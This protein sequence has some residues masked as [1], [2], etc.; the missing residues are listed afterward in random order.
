MCT[1]FQ[2]EE[3]RHARDV[4]SYAEVAALLSHLTAIRRAYD[5]GIGEEALF[6]EDGASS[7]LQMFANEG[8][9]HFCDDDEDW[10]RCRFA[11]DDAPLGWRVIQLTTDL[12]DRRMQTEGRETIDVMT[13]SSDTGASSKR[14]IR[15]FRGSRTK[16][17]RRL[18]S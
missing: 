2:E 10:V 6:L 8:G 9:N 15:S 1:R 16:G 3:D 4:Y 7:F 5:D 11:M 14:G 13:T 17:R 12:A 18:T